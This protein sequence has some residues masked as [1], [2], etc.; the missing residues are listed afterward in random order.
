MEKT[1]EVKTGDRVRVSSD[2]RFSCYL[3][4]PQMEHP[5]LFVGPQ[6]ADLRI[7]SFTVPRDYSILT[8]HCDA[9]SLTTIDV[10]PNRAAV[11]D[12]HSMLIALESDGPQDIKDLI[13]NE[14]AR[15]LALRGQLD[16]DHETIE[17]AN[18]FDMDDD[19]FGIEP[20]AQEVRELPEDREFAEQPREAAA[21]QPEDSPSAST[22]VDENQPASP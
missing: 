15:L 16:A 12:E 2:K 10:A 8:V 20:W 1:Q 5:M 6:N 19:D 9:D 18:D 14:V 13:V 17:E 3:E 21:A 7:T 11:M 22:E 4:S